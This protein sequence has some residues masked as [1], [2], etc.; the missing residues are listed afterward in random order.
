MVAAHG[1]AYLLVRSALVLAVP[2]VADDPAC[3]D[4][5]HR[6]LAGPV[7]G[8]RDGLPHA[9]LPAPDP[10]GGPHRIHRGEQHRSGR[11]LGDRRVRPVSWRPGHQPRRLSIANPTENLVLLTWAAVPPVLMYLYSYLFQ[12]I[13][14]PARYHLFIAPAYL[15]L[16]AHGLSRTQGDDRQGTLPHGHG[17][18][19]VQP[20]LELI[21][22]QAIIDRSAVLQ[23]LVFEGFE[24]ADPSALPQYNFLQADEEFVGSARLERD[25]PGWVFVGRTGFSLSAFEIRR[26]RQKK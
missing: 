6:P 23:N 24:W 2:V 10:A 19:E 16:L 26:F 13:F 12:P 1:L 9:T 7:S 18:R 25:S 8:P 4:P 3:R 5:G 21:F 20:E 11:L 15:L 14:G 22:F 17:Y